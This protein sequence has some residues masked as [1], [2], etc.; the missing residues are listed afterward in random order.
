LVTTRSLAD[1]TLPRLGQVDRE[2]EG[3]QA[4]EARIGGELAARQRRVEDAPWREQEYQ[5]LSRDYATTR[6]FYDSLLKRYEEAQLVESR[7]GKP[8]GQGLRLLDPAVTPTEP[9]A[10]DRVRLAMFGLMASL[11]LA[12]VAVAAAERLD[13]SFHSSDDLRSHTRVPI[14]VRI[15]HLSE[16]SAVDRAGRRRRS[17]LLALGLAL[18]LACAVSVSR[19]LARENEG[20][21]ALLAPRGRS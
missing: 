14:L 21:V 1:R 17:A 9:L 16:E 18:G 10:P 6:E 2:I 8:Q 15:P 13:T 7:D 5:V 4:E 12:V 20:V 19:L 11:G 3:L